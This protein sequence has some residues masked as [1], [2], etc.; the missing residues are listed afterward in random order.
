MIDIKHGDCLEVMRGMEENSIDFVVCDPP[1]MI[2]FMGKTFDKFEN[3]PAANS[4]LWK[5]ALRI[6]KP[7]S[8]LA[9]FG[10]DRTHHH[11]MNALEN[12]GWEIR[13]CIYWIFGSG[14]PK[15]LDVGKAIDKRGGKPCAFY[16]FADEYEKAIKNSNYNHSQIDDLLGIKSSSCYWSRKD[17]RGGMPPRHHWE[18]LKN[19]L[20]LPDE[21]SKIYDECEREIIS[22]EQR[23]NESSGIVS[24]GRERNLIDR[25]IS[26]P[27][28]DLA[29]KFSGYG[30][31]LKPAVEIIVLA[32]KPLDGTFAQNAEKWGI[33]GINVDESRIGLDKVESGHFNRNHISGLGGEYLKGIN[34]TET[35]N[36]S[37]GRWP[38]N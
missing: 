33:A 14:F 32:M 8:M 21:L 37:I 29:K 35:K 11:L 25:K 6:C 13:T 38:A 23:Y 34:S 7:G 4:E 26:N 27:Y 1:Y 18:K 15:S 16:K 17:C 12:S 20:S 2:G 36:Y 19:V 10:A 9:A 5:E 30:T 3:N 22:I 24:C 28:S 31:A